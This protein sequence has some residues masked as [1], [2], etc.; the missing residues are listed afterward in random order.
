MDR[1]LNSRICHPGASK[2][3]A[4]EAPQIALS[5][6]DRLCTPLTVGYMNLK[7][8]RYRRCQLHSIEVPSL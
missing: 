1:S 2:V 7:W 4:V 3:Y 5:L 8:S 6:T